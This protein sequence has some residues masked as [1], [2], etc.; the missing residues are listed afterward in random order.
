MTL[1]VRIKHQ[2][3]VTGIDQRRTTA[4]HFN[5]PAAALLAVSFLGTLNSTLSHHYFRYSSG[6]SAD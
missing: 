1:E 3:K 5:L 2:S 4:M 6:V